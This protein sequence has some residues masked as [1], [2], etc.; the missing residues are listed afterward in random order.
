MI[1]FQVRVALNN[2]YFKNCPSYTGN[3]AY[4]PG[5]R[6]PIRVILNEL[7]ENI[8]VSIKCMYFASVSK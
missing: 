8:S 3:M 7:S 4:F 6:N 2:F 5:A 1:L